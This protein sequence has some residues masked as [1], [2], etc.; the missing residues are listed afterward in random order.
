MT[1]TPAQTEPKGLSITSM[2]LGILSLLFG[3]TFLVPIA[4]VITG[5]MGMSREPAGKGFAITGLVLNGICLVGWIF[6]VITF[7]FFGGALLLFGI[8]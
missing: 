4:G 6:G 5:F 3:W 8:S 2:V 7:I 1:Y